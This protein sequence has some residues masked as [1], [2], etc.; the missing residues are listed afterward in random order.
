MNLRLLAV[1][2]LHLDAQN[3]EFVSTCYTLFTAAK[4]VAL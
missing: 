4:V 2:R 1:L 3:L